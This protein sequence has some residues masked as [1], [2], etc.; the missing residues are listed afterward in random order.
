MR[1][2]PLS[3]FAARDGSSR[4]F[5]AARI[6][7]LW[8]EGLGTTREIVLEISKDVQ[9][10]GFR[11]DDAFLESIKLYISGDLSTSSKLGSP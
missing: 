3:Y 6:S 4:T 8:E 2:K 7:E 5:I 9:S 1:L 10:L 11:D